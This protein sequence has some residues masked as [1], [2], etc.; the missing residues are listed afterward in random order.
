MDETAGSVILVLDAL[1]ECAE[2]GFQDLASMLGRQWQG[3]AQQSDKVKWLLTSRPYE[4]IT[5]EFQAF[6]ER[7]PRI[8]I[9]GEEESERISQ[10]VNLV[11]VHKIKLLARKKGLNQQI[12]NHLQDRLLNIPHR[13]YLWVYLVF[14]YLDKPFKKTKKGIEVPIDTLPETVNQAYG[15]ILERSTDHAKA[16]KAL[17]ITLAAIRPLALQEMNVALNIGSSLLRRSFQDLDL[18]SET[19]FK[20]SLRSWCGLFLSIYQG[21]VH[22]LHQTC[23]EFLIQNP[24]LLNPTRLRVSRWAHSLCSQ[25]AHRVI[26][27]ACMACVNAHPLVTDGGLSP[28]DDYRFRGEGDADSKSEAGDK[29]T[30]FSW[31]QFRNYSATH[32]VSH[33]TEA[34]IDCEDELLSAAIAL[35]HGS[36]PDTRNWIHLAARDHCELKR[37]VLPPKIEKTVRILLKRG[38]DVNVRDFSGR[39]ALH[40]AAM[41]NSTDLIMMLLKRGAKVDLQD[42]IGCGALHYAVRHRNFMTTALLIKEGANIN[43]QDEDGETALH[44]VA[45]H[46]HDPLTLFLLEKGA[47]MN[48]PDFKGE[49]ALH[50]AVRREHTPTITLLVGHGAELELRDQSDQT[51]LARAA[52]TGNESVVDLLLGSGADINLRDNSGNTILHYLVD[53]DLPKMLEFFVK[54]GADINL[55]NSDGFTAVHRA[56]FRGYRRIVTFLLDNGADFE[57]QDSHGLS[58]LQVARVCG[59]KKTVRFLEARIAQNR[60][61][62]DRQKR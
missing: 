49:T 33:L 16:Q 32:W 29:R 53:K 20:I 31:L 61:R 45:S 19:D 8:R 47:N 46:G 62:Y 15:K 44:E 36:N 48:L 43:L 18:E 35:C 9:P 25:Y 39:T 6:A 41:N 24:S 50:K 22:F 23:R 57:I 38:T 59:N 34:D 56:A 14:D 40:M 4:Q 52:M 54:S 27:E 13:T 26:A 58:P 10:E 60:A 2:S 30:A 5:S 51:P 28:T 11:I 37:H 21:R 17:C 7:F 55:A 12:Q 3:G 1:D 42:D